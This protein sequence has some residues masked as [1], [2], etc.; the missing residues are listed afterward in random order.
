MVGARAATAIARNDWQESHG[1]RIRLK[2][3]TWTDLEMEEELDHQE[4]CAGLQLLLASRDEDPH[5]LKRA[6][7]TTSGKPTVGSTPQ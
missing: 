4:A 7:P 1:Q 5:S 6:L 2:P 3:S